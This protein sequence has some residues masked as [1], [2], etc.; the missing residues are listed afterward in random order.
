MTWGLRISNP[1]GDLVLDADVPTYRYLSRPS[2]SV[3]GSKSGG[4]VN[5]YQYT[6]STGSDSLPPIVVVR[7]ASDRVMAFAGVTS[8]GGGSWRVNVFGLSTSSAM[9]SLANAVVA[10]PDVYIFVPTIAASSDTYGLR[11]WTASGVVSFDAAYKPLWLRGTV[12][13]GAASGLYFVSGG[14]TDATSWD[15]DAQSISGYS[16]LG[17]CGNPQGASQS[18][19]DVSGEPADK[20]LYGWRLNGS[21]LERR[22]FWAGTDRPAHTFDNTFDEADW[23]R[24]ATTAVLLELSIY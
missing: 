19:A 22:R 23:E 14:H 9:V 12:S 10:T 15:S 2:P 16:A 13:Y 20:W 6:V 5:P 4:V 8:L 24:K 21:N 7:P 3:A 1:G 17:V 18:T 11:L